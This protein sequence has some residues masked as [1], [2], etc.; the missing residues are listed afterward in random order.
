MHERVA[1]VG[2]G[3][4]GIA[5]AIAL[6]DHGTPVTLYEAAR[7]L[8]G[9]ARSVD[10][11][12][13]AIDN[14]QHLMIGAYRE[15]RWLLRR[16][17][18]SGMLEQRP[19]T[20]IMPGFRLQLPQLPKPLHLGFGLLTARG[21]SLREKL[22]AIHFMRH[23]QAIEFRLPVDLPVD[24]LLREQRQPDN[25][26]ERLWAPLCIAALNTPTAHASAQVFCNVLHDSLAGTRSD[27]DLLINRADLSKLVP[28][29]ALRFLE[30][31]RSHVRLAS[32]VDSIS[33]LE[34]GFLLN[35]PGTRA[36]R[37]VL[38]TH[39]TRL[40][41]L[42]AGMPEMTRTLS[43]IGL[44][45]WQPILTLWLRF[46]RSLPFHFPMLGL[47]DRHAPWAFERNDI[48]SGMVS[49]V[50]SAQGPHLHWPHDKLLAEYLNLLARTFGDL[51]RLL[52]W[53][54][55]V[56]KRAT[57]TC[58]PDQFRPNNVTP[59]SGLYLAGDFTA[60]SA[61]TNTYPATLEGA[62]RSGVECARLIIAEQK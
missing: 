56:E 42:L 1:I 18:T 37:V 10:W 34:R 39:P 2:G 3:W 62:V 6:A 22:A 8:G 14:G 13:L 11:D 23:L 57:Y 47:G 55:I 43:Q 15:T 46:E 49:L 54:V 28:T 30:Q 51:P 32:K 58:E 48:A 20:L 45:T 60:G 41:A 27:S 4:A 52:A 35:G 12:G 53:K 9:R 26:I 31:H 29:A 40:P 24:A 16:L 17:G 21:L 38:A 25:L 61:S 50:M 36:E 7:Q 5:C 44:Y 19:L 59:I 33:R